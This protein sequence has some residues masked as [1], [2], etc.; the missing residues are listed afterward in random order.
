MHHSGTMA[1]MASSNPGTAFL[2]ICIAATAAAAV[3]CL[4][5][6]VATA[7]G[8]AEAS[9]P[10]IL[11]LGISTGLLVFATFAL[12]VELLDRTPALVDPARA[13]GTAPLL[14]PAAAAAAPPVPPA[15]RPRLLRVK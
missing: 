4:Y 6:A 9:A 15:G 2:K 14:S 8:T 12:M 7:L 1:A 11:A 3:A 5:A 13:I 10:R